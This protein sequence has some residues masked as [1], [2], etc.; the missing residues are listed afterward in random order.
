MKSAL[1]PKAPTPLIYNGMQF[2]FKM[3]HG[4]VGF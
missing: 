2:D 1:F 4:A 3:L